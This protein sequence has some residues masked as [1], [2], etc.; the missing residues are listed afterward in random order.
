MES[1]PEPPNASPGRRRSPSIAPAEEPLGGGD[2]EA[3][4]WLD[5]RTDVLTRAVDHG[6]SC[7]LGWRAVLLAEMA[8]ADGPSV[9]VPQRASSG[10]MEQQ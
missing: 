5:L 4:F 2:M 7:L 1:S 6:G 9:R 8:E 10:Q 3:D